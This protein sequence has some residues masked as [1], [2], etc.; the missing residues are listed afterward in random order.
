MTDSPNTTNLS[1]A[2]GTTPLVRQ[3]L[4]L[5]ADNPDHLLFFRVGAFYD[6]YF[7]DAEIAAGALGLALHRRSMPPMAICKTSFEWGIARRSASK[8]KRRRRR[9]SAAGRRSCAVT[10][11][12]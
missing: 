4:A 6:L 3:Y 8:S 9:G 11:C 2:Q 1:D 12:A 5:K 10:W 7:N